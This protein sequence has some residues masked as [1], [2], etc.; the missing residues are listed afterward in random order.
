MI[1]TVVMTHPRE[2]DGVMKYHVYRRVGFTQLTYQTSLSPLL[3]YS[4]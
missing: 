3:A 1:V 2:K 4:T